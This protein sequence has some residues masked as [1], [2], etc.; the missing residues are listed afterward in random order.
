MV[1]FLTRLGLDA[2]DLFWLPMAVWTGIAV[3][4]LAGLRALPDRFARIH[5]DARV[6]LLAAIPVAL[7]IGL[8]IP[9]GGAESAV[10]VISVP[11]MPAPMP[12]EIADSIP[13]PAPIGMP[14]W[15]GWA[16]FVAGVASVAGLA[17][18]VVGWVRMRRTI[19]RATPLDDDMTRDAVDEIRRRLD[20]ATRVRVLRSEEVPVP[21]SVGVFRPAVILPADLTDLRFDVLLHEIVHHRDGDMVRS[22]I[23]ECVRSAFVFHPLIHF[24]DR[25]V[26]L[27]VELACDARVLSQPEVRKNSY[28]ELLLTYAQAARLN[29]PAVLPMADSTSQLQRRIQA[30][31]TPFTTRTPAGLVRTFALL[32]FAASVGLAACT[33]SDPGLLEA[34]ALDARTGEEETFVI[35]EQNPEPIGGLAALQEHVVYPDLAKKAGVQG[36]VYLQFVVTKDG[37]PE[38]IVITRGIGAGCDEAAIEAVKQM[39]FVPGKQRGEAVRVKMSLPVNFTLKED[40]EMGDR[41]VS[42]ATS[43]HLGDGGSY[44]ATFIEESLRIVDEISRTYEAV[45]ASYET[46]S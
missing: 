20:L 24:V 10:P 27:Y 4:V 32:V 38:D 34:D 42:P 23:T 36:K 12:P 8:L 33:K 2:W 17:G 35:V 1:D 30:M 16:T 14:F 26:R 3:L 21:I 13:A 6:A 28:A 22:W 25:Q 31:K 45:R 9:A 19:R 40:M 37:Y 46:N 7:I 41:E 44:D 43:A 5:V 18:L 39:R 29:R 15:I 11:R